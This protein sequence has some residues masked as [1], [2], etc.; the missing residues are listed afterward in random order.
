MRTVVQGVTRT[1][2]GTITD[3]GGPSPE[4]LVEVTRFTIVGGTVQFLPPQIDVTYTNL[5][6]PR[7]KAAN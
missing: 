7:A 2:N 1:F 5:P 6:A 4:V 3:D